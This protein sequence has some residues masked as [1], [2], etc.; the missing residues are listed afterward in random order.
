MG[1]S[2]EIHPLCRDG[3]GFRTGADAH[4]QGPSGRP[5]QPV[6]QVGLAGLLGRQWL[7]GA[8]TLLLRD[9]CK[10]GA[11]ADWI[12]DALVRKDDYRD[13]LDAKLRRS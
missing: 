9:D 4:S 10:T 1:D 6:H 13:K 7:E 3:R 12:S 5:L 2:P 11:E 8:A